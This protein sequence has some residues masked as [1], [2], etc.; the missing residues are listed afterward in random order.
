MEYIFDQEKS[1]DRLY[2]EEIKKTAGDVQDKDVSVQKVMLEDILQLYQYYEK[3][4]D[5]SYLDMA[6]L[7]IRA[8][9][10]MGFSYDLGK[11]FFDM[12]FDK[13]NIKK[14]LYFS[15]E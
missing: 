5:D 15:E 12:I 7:H 14:E 11:G 3:T 2:I 13:L 9:W 1:E 8:F 10:E 4:K 6:V